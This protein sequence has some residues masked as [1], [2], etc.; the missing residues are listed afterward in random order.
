MAY[1]KQA[2]IYPALLILHGGGNNA[3]GMADKVQV[4]ANRGFV[5]LAIDLPGI[6]GTT[7]T[8]YSS[9]PWKSKPSGDGPK[10]LV[11]PVPGVSTLADAEIAGLQAFNLLRSQVNV[12]STKM[13]IVGTSWGGYSTTMLSGLLG[14]KVVA[15]YSQFGCGYYDKGTLWSKTIDSLPLTDRNTWITNFDAG[16]RAPNIKAAYFIE[17]ASNDNY[18]WPEAVSA[19]LNAIK[20]TKNMVIVPNSNHVPTPT[21]TAMMALYFDYYLKG[22]GSPF[23]KIDITGTTRQ[24]DGSMLVSMSLSVPP[25]ITLSAVK[26]YYSLQSASWQQRTWVGVNATT[27]SDN[28]YSAL[29]PSSAV[30]AGANLYAYAQDSRTIVISSYMEK[31]Q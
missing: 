23:G 19:T 31:V 14:D 12:D 8:P 16:R 27:V 9:G 3:E 18:F 5:T 20:S 22:I 30:T 21:S 29:L 11:I 28:T 25:G 7:N 17:S 15:A 26:L 4:F 24:A 13:G 2:G 10:F 1:P 6:C